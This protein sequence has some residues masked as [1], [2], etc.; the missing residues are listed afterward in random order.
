MLSP[1][2]REILILRTAWLCRSEYVWAHHVATAKKIGLA[3]DEIGRIAE[4]PN[5]RGWGAF[6]ER[7][8]VISAR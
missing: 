2:H 3:N 8:P 6:A 1:R 7:F 4:G 5:A